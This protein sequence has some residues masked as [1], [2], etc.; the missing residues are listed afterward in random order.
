MQEEKN[1]ETIKIGDDVF[2]AEKVK[3]FLFSY[4]NIKKEAILICKIDEKEKII[5]GKEAVKSYKRIKIAEY[6]GYENL[7]YKEKENFIKT[8][9]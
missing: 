4:L 9:W 8:N 1:Y 3:V 5:E 6:K 7:P 2:P